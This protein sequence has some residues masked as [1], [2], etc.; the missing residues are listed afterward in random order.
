[1]KFSNT[2]LRPMLGF[3]LLFA[4]VILSSCSST[5][6]GSG[7]VIAET[8]DVSDFN[9]VSLNGIGNLHIEQGNSESLRIVGENNIIATIRTEVDDNELKIRYEEEVSPT[10]PIDFFLT[11]KD[12]QAIDLSGLGAISS[13]GLNVDQLSV[14][15]SG[16]GEV[17]LVVQ[18]KEFASIMS[19]SA[20]VQVSGGVDRQR[21]VIAGSGRY[22]AG[23]LTS[24]ECDINISGSGNA[25]VNV[26]NKLDVTIN[27][28]GE[29]AYI[30]N[31]Q[32]S[33]QVSGTGTIRQIR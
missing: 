11:V 33:Q 8:R 2:I 23:E 5:V 31:P 10:K 17:S 6:T 32:V 3:F 7:N 19:G 26:R 16:S 30:G 4:L 27:G 18:A 21:V 20:N 28:S 14:T 24:N 22:N 13:T 12:L 1:M 29:V 15:S 25:T 9:K